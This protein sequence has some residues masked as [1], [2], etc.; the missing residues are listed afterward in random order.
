LRKRILRGSLFRFRFFIAG[1]F[2]SAFLIA[3][4]ALLNFPGVKPA[5]DPQREILI[6]ARYPRLG[7]C[8][9]RLA[10]GVGDAD[11]LRIY[12]ALLDHTLA[13]V[14]D[15]SF[16]KVL[17]IDPPEHVA[18]AVDWAPGMDAYRAQSAGDLGERMESAVDAAFR[19]G[20]NRVLLLGC[21]CPQISKD[22][23]NSSFD[24]LEACDVVLGPTDDGGYYLLGLKKGHPY[25]FRDIPWSSGKEFEK[26]LN[27]LK[28][29][30]LSYISQD[31]L[32]DVDT[33]EDYDR[34]KHLEPLKHLGIR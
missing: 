31:I 8:K 16:R 32:S 28:F 18:D 17:V 20:A 26:T 3:A 21:D 15:T 33:Q 22:T 19:E 23:V 24:A 7:R 12:R 14:R 25:L 11:A 1:F 4:D 30:S 34:V 9:T 5:S 29:H 13:V 6:F 27:I 10:R 2:P